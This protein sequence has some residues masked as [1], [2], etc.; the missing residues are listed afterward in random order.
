MR[1]DKNSD[2]EYCTYMETRRK[3]KSRQTNSWRR[4]VVSSVARG[5]F[6]LDL[7]SGSLADS[8]IQNRRGTVLDRTH[9]RLLRLLNLLLEYNTMSSLAS[10]QRVVTGNY[11]G[12][13]FT[14]T[15]HRR[16]GIGKS[17]KECSNQNGQNIEITSFRYKSSQYISDSVSAI[18]RKRHIDSKILETVD[19]S[20][21]DDMYK[22]SIYTQNIENYLGTVKV[23]IGIVNVN[24]NGMHAN[25][26]YAV[27]LATTE[28]AMVASY[29]RGCKLINESGG[30]NTVVQEKKVQRAPE[31]VF[32]SLSDAY[33]FFQWFNRPEL[34]PKM[35]GVA[36]STTNHGKLINIVAKLHGNKV[37]TKW[38]YESGNASGQNICTFATDAAI[39][40]ILTEAPIQ[41]EKWYLEAGASQD[42][43]ASIGLFNNSRGIYVTGELVCPKEAVEKIMKTTGRHHYWLNIDHI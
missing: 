11:V 5:R 34:F 9:H 3:K 39:T 21:L 8:E 10:L 22:D 27:P 12:R 31:F 41:P 26:S 17:L 38:M 43:K 4:S 24:V 7:C 30:L 25:G 1:M 29:S 19:L 28:S 36:E 42:K 2:Q 14:M 33:K 20:P 13:F 23:P 6:R 37:I 15:L 18:N 35:K 16:T 40:H 32:K